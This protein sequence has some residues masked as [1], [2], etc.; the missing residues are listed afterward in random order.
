MVFKSF[1]LKKY[2]TKKIKLSNILTQMFIGLLIIQR[3]RVKVREKE[4][5]REGDRKRE[6][7]RGRWDIQKEREIGRERE[8]V[9]ER[10]L[11]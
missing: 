4:R 7:K 2:V 9:W 1:K 3:E 8:R 5:E 10:I 6:W 11:G